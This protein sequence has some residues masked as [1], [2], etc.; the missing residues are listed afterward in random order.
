[1]KLA[2]ALILAP[3][4]LAASTGLAEDHLGKFSQIASENGN[5]RYAGTAGYNQSLEYVKGL[6]APHYDITVDSFQFPDF[7]EVVAPVVKQVAPEAKE[8]PKE[9]FSSMIFSGSGDLKGAAI[10]AVDVM[11]PPAEKPNSST[12]G[13]E[14]E[15][16]YADGK[17]IVEG[18][19]ALIQRGSCAFGKKATNAVA[20]K[21]IGVIIFNEGT[22]N[23]PERSET[24]KDG[25]LGEVLTIPVLGASF[26]AG[27]EV[28]DQ[29]AAGKAVTLD[30]AVT[31]KNTFLDAANLLAESKTGDASRVVMVGAN[32][33]SAKNS[34]GM[35]SNAAGA[36]AVLSAALAMAGKEVHNKMRF[37]FWG[38]DLVGSSYYTKALK[39]EDADRI[40][41]Y[42]NFDK[43]ASLNY[44]R[45]V[46]DSV[47]TA[48][49]SAVAEQAFDSFFK[50]K[51]LVTE[52]IPGDNGDSDHFWFGEMGIPTG[53]MT[54]GAAAKKTDAQAEKF[55]GT[56]GEPFDKCAGE[57]CDTIDNVEKTLAQEAIAAATAVSESLAQFKGVIR[58]KTATATPRS[59]AHNAPALG[60]GVLY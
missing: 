36:S 23:M 25:N 18:K 42:V 10:A 5:S 40:Q 54:A 8:L 28:Y 33:G 24:V 29:L 59:A 41:L 12:S 46:F 37:S 48:K 47:N 26:G 43:V 35:N 15:D 55:G 7:E 34:P 11:M 4:V 6:L 1:M 31:T 30:L 57:P 16:F 39:K 49:G 19:I 27:K 51:T 60:G 44:G 3:L 22:P 13:C 58:E 32:L 20:A 38:G 45:F 53:G 50:G 17:S 52:K 14:A 21:A 2:S 9:N 56:A